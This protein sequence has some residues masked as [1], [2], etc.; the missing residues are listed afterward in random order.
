MQALISF[1]NTASSVVPANP[2]AKGA[3]LVGQFFNSLN[4]VFQPSSND[5]FDPDFQLSFGLGRTDTTCNDLQLR[6]GVGAE[7]ADYPGSEAD[8]IVKISNLGE[9]CFYKLGNGRDPDIGFVRKQGAACAGEAPPDAKIL[10]NP[11]FIW[12]AYGTCKDEH[13]CESASSETPQHLAT[14]NGTDNSLLNVLSARLP[15]I[16]ETDSINVRRAVNEA[17]PSLLNH[18]SKSTARLVHGLALCSSVGIAANRC[19]DHRFSS[20]EP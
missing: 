2:Y 10:N 15:S 11:Q 13:T 14:L 12:M 7:I 19:F 18:V 20:E 16:K 4:T 6:D 3:Q 17:D 1:T 9:Y 8:G 5:Q